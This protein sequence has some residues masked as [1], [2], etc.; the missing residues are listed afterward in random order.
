MKKFN[1][2]IYSLTQLTLILSLHYLVKSRSRSLGV[3]KNKFIHA[4]AT[5][6]IITETRKLLKI[7]YMFNINDI[8]FN[9]VRLQTE[10]TR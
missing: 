2:K 6:Q 5:A 4:H 1:V 3:Y 7:F 8:N 10:M 9:S